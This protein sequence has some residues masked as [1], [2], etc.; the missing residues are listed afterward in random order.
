MTVWSARPPR[1]GLWLFAAILCAGLSLSPDVEAEP[2]LLTFYNGE[3]AILGQ[4]KEDVCSVIFPVTFHP[5]LNWRNTR[6]YAWS[7]TGGS[8]TRSAG[9]ASAA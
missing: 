6:F 5:E 9:G 4:S 3:P 1:A 2:P 7:D 8:P